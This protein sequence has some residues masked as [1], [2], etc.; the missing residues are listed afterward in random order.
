VK[1]ALKKLFLGK[2]KG[3]ATDYADKTPEK[4]E[5]P[6]VVD[7]NELEITPSTKMRHLLAVIQEKLQDP[8]V[9]VVAY[10]QFTSFLDLCGAFLRKEGVNVL[11]YQGSM[12]APERQNTLDRFNTPTD[13]E[14][15]ESR[16]LLLSLKA[17]GVGLNLTISNVVIA[18]DLAW[19][20]ATGE[21]RL[22]SH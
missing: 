20:A 16:V 3:K 21:S 11:Q 5:K 13:L 9:K 22:Q 4:E 2:G 7:F 15:G 10:S 8:T 1:P 6:A 14:G 12:K 18:L 19:N 17:G